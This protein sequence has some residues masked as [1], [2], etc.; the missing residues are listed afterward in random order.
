MSGRHTAKR[1]SVHLVL[2]VAMNM[3]ANVLLQW[4]LARNISVTIRCARRG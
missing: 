4:N 3:L 2:F 1:V